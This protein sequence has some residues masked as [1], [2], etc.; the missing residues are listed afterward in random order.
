MFKE[1]KN[2]QAADGKVFSHKNA[3]GDLCL[4]CLAYFGVCEMEI[5]DSRSTHASSVF[6]TDHHGGQGVLRCYNL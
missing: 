3:Y 5:H 1:K 4:S 2:S 6:L